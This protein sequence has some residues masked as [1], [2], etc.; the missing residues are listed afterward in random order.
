MVKRKSL[1][2]AQA[3]RSLRAFY[4][5]KAGKRRG[6]GTG[7]KRKSSK[8]RSFKRGGATDKEEE[9][10]VF[11]HL[12]GAV[13]GVTSGVTGAVGAV[14]KG[15]T[16]AVGSVASTVTKPFMGGRKRSKQRRSKQKKNKQKKKS[17]KKKRRRRR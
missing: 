17:S 8:R 4:A 14:A 9:K 10:G 1:T 3:R 5:Q 13:H 7:H 15:A 16:G 12:T 11:G 6:C 2:L